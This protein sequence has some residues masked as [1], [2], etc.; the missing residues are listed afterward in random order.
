MGHIQSRTEARLPLARILDPRSVA[1]IGASEDVGK[2]GGRVLHHLIRHDYAGRIV[3]VNPNRPA[4]FGIPAVPSI[5]EAGAVDVA[6][7]ALPAAQLEGAVAAC[8][9]AG[10]GAVVIITAQMA[11]SG[12]EGAE[13]QRRIVAVARAAGM[14]ILG[15]N[16]LGFVNTRAGLALTSSFAMGVERLP[17]G[18]VGLV[19]QSGALMATMFNAGYDIGVGFGTLVSVGNQADVTEAEV[20]AHLI[21]DPDTRAIVLYLEGV[22]DGRRFLEEAERARA[23]GKPVVA[24]K[25]GRSEAGQRA[26]LSHTASLAG[27]FRLFEAAARARGVVLADDPEAAVAIADALARWPAGLPRGTGV[28]PVSGSGGGA[29]I[30][31]DRLADA[32]LPLA[33]LTEATRTR[34]A[35]EL[36]PGQPPLPFDAGATRGGFAAPA[37]AGALGVLAADETVGALVYVMTTQ[38]QMPEIAAALAEVGRTA[39]KP[40]LLVLSAGSVADGLRATLRDAGY[41]YHNRLDDALRVLRGLAD[42]ADA[43]S[44]PGPAEPPD[45]RLAAALAALPDG[46]LTAPEARTLVEAAG[47][48]VAGEAVAAS[49]D[50]AVVAAQRFGWPVVL[51]L[52]SRTVSHKSDRGGVRLGL[53][54]ADA[55]RAAFHDLAAAFG[56]DFEG[57]LVQPQV[58]GV[59]ELIVGTLWDDAYGPFVL[60]GS[61]GLFAE[62][63]DDTRVAPAPLDAAR[64]EALLGGL[65]VWPVLNGARGRPKADIG[66]AVA[67]I[68]AA[69]RLAAA[70]GPR[71]R[72]L[73]VNPLILRA[74]GQGGLAVDARARLSTPA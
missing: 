48:P 15:P 70:L 30:V 2:F 47:I 6:A 36:P 60:V 40:V 69:G 73:D 9:A 41:P 24:V 54:G 20:F 56:T 23:A 42:R 74:D 67:T 51:K 58:Q 21:D 33:A 17:V 5:A 31:A 32:G 61:G 16:C 14:R 55:V 13:R 62:L 71:L 53:T 72:E 52:V 68:V 39:G 19:S 38:P 35:A 65:K 7:I 66:A 45:A 43:P 37:V 4:L 18:P 64:A 57:A 27:P 1:V 3:P 63:L 59:A 50:A 8:A 22:S 44:A 26:A 46:P 11:E 28:A 49:A 12:A 29:A 34:L 25:A 10:V